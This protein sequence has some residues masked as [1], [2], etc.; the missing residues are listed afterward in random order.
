MTGALVCRQ[1]I[2]LQLLEGPAPQ[3]KATFARIRRDDRHLEIKKLVSR[4]VTDRIFGDWAMLHDPA[5]SWIW[6]EEELTKGILDSAT[7]AEIGKVF[8]DLADR[9]ENGAME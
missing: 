4:Q 3:V 8:E 2:Y 5:K 6:S 9:I 7:E 1:D